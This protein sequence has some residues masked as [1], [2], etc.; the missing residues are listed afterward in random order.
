MMK[1]INLKE[2]PLVKRGDASMLLGDPQKAKS[3]PPRLERPDRS[4]TRNLE[5]AA[6]GNLALALPGHYEITHAPA[7]AN[8]TYEPATIRLIIAYTKAAA[9]HYA[10]IETDLIPLAIEDTDEFL[11]QQRHYECETRTCLCLYDGLRR[12][13]YAFRPCFSLC[14]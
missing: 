2:D 14:R 12:K 4:H 11:S 3:S 6:P 13:R 10:D 9:E 1:K 7:Q 8:E 5:D